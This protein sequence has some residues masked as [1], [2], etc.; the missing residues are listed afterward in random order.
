MNKSAL[1]K[2]IIFLTLNFLGLYLG[3][4]F[5]TQGVASEWYTTANKSPITPPG[6]FFGFA[7]TTIM[8]CLAFYMT[9]A[10]NKSAISNK[11]LL[12]VYAIQWVLNFLWNPV[13][14]TLHFVGLGLITIVILALIVSAILFTFLK[15]M[16]WKSILILPYFLWIYVASYLNLYIFLNN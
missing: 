5:T 4:F 9:I 6:W 1:L 7:W 8:V 13:F 11:K 14:F 12:A 3:S 2:F 15:T 10:H 16:Q